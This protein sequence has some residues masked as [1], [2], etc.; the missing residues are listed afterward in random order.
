MA[1]AINPRQFISL[2]YNNADMYGALSE[3]PAPGIPLQ[4]AIAPT[5]TGR[6][7]TSTRELEKRLWQEETATKAS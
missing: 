3:R 1:D 7:N 5:E 2:D 6:E 4:K